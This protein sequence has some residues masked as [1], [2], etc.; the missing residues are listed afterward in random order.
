MRWPRISLA[1]LAFTSVVGCGFVWRTRS[2]DVRAVEAA[3]ASATADSK[4]PGTPTPVEDTD[5]TNTPA[6]ISTYPVYAAHPED[7]AP[8]TP[9]ENAD[10]LD[11]YFSTTARTT[12]AVCATKRCVGGT[13]AW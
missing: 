12:I 11:Y 9:I 1:I 3:S 6:E 4:T 8:A 2:H 10:R 7:A 5:R 13:A